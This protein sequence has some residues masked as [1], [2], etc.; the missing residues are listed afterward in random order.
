MALDSVPWFVGGGAE[1]S[2]E[3]ARLLAYAATAGASGVVAPGDL[4]VTQTPV[5]G[6]N[7][8]VATGGGVIPN[9]YP[10][11]GQQTYIGRAASVTDT[12]VTATGSASG[13]V[14]LVVARIDDPQYG[15]AA[16]VDPTV[17][18]YIRIAIIENVA[19]GSTDLPAGTAYPAIA[20][21][22]LDIPASTATIT[23]AMITPLCKLANPRQTRTVL[24]SQPALQSLTSATYVDWPSAY[25]PTVAIPAW[26]THFNLIAHMSA[27]VHQGGD[28]VGYAK[29]LLGTVESAPVG[30]DTTGT[31]ENTRE[32][33]LVA[34]SAA[35][36]AMAG[37]T[38]TIKIRGQRIAG[39]GA[40]KIWAA[41][42]IVYDIEFLEKV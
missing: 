37:T 40:M 13:R 3:V 19:A 2:P 16:P 38:Q 31:V 9:L 22:R 1:H 17:G 23:T 10:G 5:A 12:P 35:V 4:K 33:I 42:T 34:S 11:G 32:N 28:A 18:P 36:G 8:R 21:A 39:A 14:D 25:L 20:L 30:Y 41:T 7:I 26:A 29:V 6:T 27:L 15:G 24:T